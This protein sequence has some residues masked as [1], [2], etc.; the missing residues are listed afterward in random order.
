MS[1]VAW[2]QELS[3]VNM[4]NHALAYA[5]KGWA[6]LPVWW[7]SYAGVCACPEGKNC[8]P[9]AKHPISFHGCKDSTTD[10][11]EIRKWWGQHPNAN[12]GITTGEPSGFSVLDIDEAHDGGRSMQMLM[13]RHGRPDPTLVSLTGGGGRHILWQWHKSHKCSQNLYPGIDV[14]ST[15]GYILAPPS[16][17]A[18]GARYEWHEMGH[19]RNAKLSEAPRWAWP[20]LSGKLNGISRGKRN[21]SAMPDGPFAE[22]ARNTSLFRF[23]CRFQRLGETDEDVANKTHDLNR[24]M[25]QP[26]LRDRE[27]ERIIGS[28]LRYPKGA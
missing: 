16:L 3:S 14:R 6:V 1:E 13:R 27:V 15:G 10:E 19:P 5:K 23:A 12:I 20:I 26:P 4:L 28:A 24:R 7:P 8:G 21:G 25:C 9:V 22:G 18:S 2:D 11:G 17:H